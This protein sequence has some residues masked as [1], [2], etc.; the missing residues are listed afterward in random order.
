MTAADAGGE[1]TATDKEL[2]RLVELDYERTAEFINGVTTTMATIRG[3]AI[4]IW[5]AIL[6]IGLE[7]SLWQVTLLAAASAGV[8][9][10]LDGYHAWL[11]G[12]AL[13]HAA[14]L[15][16]LSGKYF[17]SL[18]RGAVDDDVE[19]DFQV[20]L[21]SHRFGM[22]RNFRR[23][24]FKDL[25]FVKPYVFFR[26]FYPFLVGV[27]ILATILLASAQSADDPPCTV[28]RDEEAVTVKCGD[29]ELIDRG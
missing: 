27:A 20:A 29:V 7:R 28:D 25:R 9:L 12:E 10:L 22:Y 8:F 18:G 11:Y 26:A 1:E 17:D 15:E 3:W 13:A 4:T 5:L 14:K 21:E 2:V 23:F 16:R 6:G 19:L 24:R